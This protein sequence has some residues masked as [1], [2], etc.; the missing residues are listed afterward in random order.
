M[1]TKELLT[2]AIEL[3][4]EGNNVDAAA[5]VSEASAADVDNT[6]EALSDK[7]YSDLLLEDDDVAT[8]FKN[9][10]SKHLELDTPATPEKETVVINNTTNEKGSSVIKWVVIAIIVI[11]V[12][13]FIGTML[14]VG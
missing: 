13:Y 11:I 8:K 9:L 7:L 1:N 10:F 14:S 5:K 6:F 12:L 3:L 4:K 2:Q